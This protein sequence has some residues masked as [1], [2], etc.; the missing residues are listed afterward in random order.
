MKC[1]YACSSTLRQESIITSLWRAL[2]VKSVSKL[3]LQVD[4]I[5][6]NRHLVSYRQVLG[7]I[8]GRD[9]ID[10]FFSPFFSFFFWLGSPSVPLEFPKLANAQPSNFGPLRI[11]YSILGQIQIMG[12]SNFAHCVFRDCLLCWP[13]FNL[14]VCK[15]FKIGDFAACRFKC[16]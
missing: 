2:L 11:L 14:F 6:Q 1:Q 4:L 5:C 15:H 9:S 16:I 8:P 13:K 10:F 7:S 12:N 3:Y